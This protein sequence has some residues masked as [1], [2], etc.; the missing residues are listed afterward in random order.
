MIL[1]KKI[2]WNHNNL[3]VITNNYASRKIM[4]K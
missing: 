4:N 1:L 2:W 3:C